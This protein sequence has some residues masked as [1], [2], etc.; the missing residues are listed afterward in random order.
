MAIRH[1]ANRYI[2]L[3]DT[4]AKMEFAQHES[5]LAGI[6]GSCSVGPWCDVSYFE[7]C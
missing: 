5:T 3:V 2:M 6:L 4:A 1:T 7:V